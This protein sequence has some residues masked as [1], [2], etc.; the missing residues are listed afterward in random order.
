MSN[1]V[2]II[3]HC[4]IT[5][6]FNPQL[7][8]KK[9]LCNVQE[10]LTGSKTGENELLCLMICCM[11]KRARGERVW[12]QSCW[13]F[14]PWLRHKINTLFLMVKLDGAVMGTFCLPCVFLAPSLS[15]DPWH[16][17]LHTDVSKRSLS[18]S[19]REC[20]L[21]ATPAA[22]VLAE[23]HIQITLKPT[24]FWGC[25]IRPLSD[26]TDWIGPGLGH[27]TVRVAAFTL[28]WRAQASPDQPG[29]WWYRLY[30]WLEARP[31]KFTKF[32]SSNSDAADRGKKQKQ[33]QKHRI[34]NCQR[35][36]VLGTLPS[37]LLHLYFYTFVLFFFFLMESA[38]SPLSSIVFTSS[39]NDTF[40]HAVHISAGKASD[41]WPGCSCSAEDGDFLW[42]PVRQPLF[43]GDSALLLTSLLLSRCFLFS[44]HQLLGVE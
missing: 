31:F 5:W 34:N 26:G 13:Q 11:Q 7:W 23:L 24:N 41:W 1:E 9:S 42:V 20:T 16:S 17:Y 6:L 19:G 18:T 36:A 39:K 4:W 3:L 21:I 43:A 14:K 40:C 38:F 10:G 44:L 15:S 2:C 12:W 37:C 35:V 28:L 33:P 8:G 27:S 25:C 29:G 22:W 30:T 32:T